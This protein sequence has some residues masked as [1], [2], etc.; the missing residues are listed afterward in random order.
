MADHLWFVPVSSGNA[1]DEATAAFPIAPTRDLTN[2]QWNFS[3]Y[4][5]GQQPPA[6]VSC[7]SYNSYTA[8]TM[9]QEGPPI[10]EAMLRECYARWTW[11]SCTDNTNIL[12]GGQLAVGTVFAREL[13]V[14][15]LE[16]HQLWNTWTDVD[17]WA[18][19]R[20]DVPARLDGIF[21]SLNDRGGNSSA[22]P[23]LALGGLTPAGTWRVAYHTFNQFVQDEWDTP[24]TNLRVVMSFQGTT[25]PA[26][27][28]VVNVD[29]EWFAIRLRYVEE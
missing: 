26:N 24:S 13:P 27:V 16:P 1:P 20:V 11:R 2:V 28:D 8:F 10:V 9:A 4:P 14:D 23:N 12:N 25:N 18:K 21:L 22:G 5:V 15:N 29:M 7:L 6:E 17:I 19:Y 3:V